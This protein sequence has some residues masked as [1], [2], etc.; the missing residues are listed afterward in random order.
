MAQ[1]DLRTY[2]RR[3][4]TRESGYHTCEDTTGGECRIVYSEKHISGSKKESI[5]FHRNELVLVELFEKGISL[6]AFGGYIHSQS[7]SE[8]KF[9]MTYQ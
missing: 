7:K 2:H 3:E 9:R 1:K 4:T 6:I 5:I 8:V